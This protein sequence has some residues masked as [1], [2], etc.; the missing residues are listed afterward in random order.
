MKSEKY[1]GWSAKER[2]KVGKIKEG[3]EVRKDKSSKGRKKKGRRG[4]K[5]EVSSDI[6]RKQPNVK[7]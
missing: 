2:R 7:M 6:C 1:K 4:D 5:K 3:K